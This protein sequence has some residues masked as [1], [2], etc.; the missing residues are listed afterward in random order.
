MIR[1]PPRYT[2][3]DTLFP[4]TT[5]FRSA[6]AERLPLRRGHLRQ[7]LGLPE[8]RL[9]EGRFAHGPETSASAGAVQGQGTGCTHLMEERLALAT[10]RLSSRHL[11]PGPTALATQ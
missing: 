3:T 2:R 11:L 8:R 6:V 4:Y 10:Q 1:R 5:L 9:S 7:G